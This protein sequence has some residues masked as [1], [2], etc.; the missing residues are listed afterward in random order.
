MNKKI[1][2]PEITLTE[3]IAKTGL[4]EVELLRLISDNLILNRKLLLVSKNQE[5]RQDNAKAIEEKLRLR[6]KSIDR[7]ML[8]EEVFIKELRL[9]DLNAT[10]K[11]QGQ[12][13]I[14]KGFYINALEIII[15]ELMI[16]EVNS[17]NEQMINSYINGKVKDLHH[18]L[19]LPYA[20]ADSDS[21]KSLIIKP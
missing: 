19:N 7:K 5:I 12:A 15:G 10:E 14:M 6:E 8:E 4:N 9:R 3:V 13:E 16:K 20:G 18:K 11:L 1:N 17:G 2:K 21:K